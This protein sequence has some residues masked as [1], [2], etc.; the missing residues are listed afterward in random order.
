MRLVAIRQ[1]LPLSCLGLIAGAVTN[2]V[3]FEQSK[4]EIPEFKLEAPPKFEECFFEK[5]KR[6]YP[7]IPPRRLR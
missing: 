6:T 7:K 1:G 2:S 4:I 3:L 5:P